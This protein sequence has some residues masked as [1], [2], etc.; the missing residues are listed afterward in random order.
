M[1]KERVFASLNSK[2]I[3]IHPN[4]NCR[5][6]EGNANIKESFQADDFISHA[7]L[8]EGSILRTNSCCGV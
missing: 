2:N 5:T 4:D 7:A 6:S 1:V 8:E 3:H